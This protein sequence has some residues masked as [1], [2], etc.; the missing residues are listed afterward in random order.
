MAKG[1]SRPTVVQKPI[2][3]QKPPIKD[4][5]TYIEKGMESPKK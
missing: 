5:N 4:T 3:V 2:V 1:S